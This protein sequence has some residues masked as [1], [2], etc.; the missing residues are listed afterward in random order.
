MTDR[1][2]AE[3]Y[4]FTAYRV[5]PAQGKIEARG[6][7]KRRKTDKGSMESGGSGELDDAMSQQDDV[8]DS[9]TSN[10]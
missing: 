8:A 9:N 3:G 1:G 2:G 10:D 7:H 6:N 5:I 4:L